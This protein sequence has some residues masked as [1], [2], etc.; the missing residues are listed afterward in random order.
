MNHSVQTFPPALLPAEDL[1]IDREIDCGSYVVTQDDIIE[2]ARSWDP[3]YFHVNP[4]LAVHSDFGGLIGS[5]VHTLAIFQ[6]L[7][8]AAVYAKYDVVAGKHMRDLRFLRP[9]KP[10]DELTAS[11]LVRSVEPDGRGRCLVTMLGTLRNQHGRPVLEVEVDSLL[12]SR[13]TRG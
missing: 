9:V 12:R 3:Q 6:R 4:G 7:A 5:G 11:L 13:H 2:F 10:G 1:P 8:V